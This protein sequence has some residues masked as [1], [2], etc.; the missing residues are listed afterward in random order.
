MLQTPNSVTILSII[1]SRP[2]YTNPKRHNNILPR[3]DVCVI[4]V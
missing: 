4:A 1:V 3:D 2:K